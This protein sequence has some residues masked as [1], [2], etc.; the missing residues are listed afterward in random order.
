[1]VMVGASPEQLDRLAS[2]L[3]QAA[4]QIG[5]GIRVGLDR[6]I[7]ANPWQGGDAQR[8][9][10]DWQSHLSP[11]LLRTSESLEQVAEH[12]RLQAEE[13]RV[14]SSANGSGDSTGRGFAS[15]SGGSTGRGFVGGGGGGGGGGGWGDGDDQSVDTG[16]WPF[17][18]LNTLK[19][20]MELPEKIAKGVV[21]PGILTRLGDMEGVFGLSTEYAIL[22]GETDHILSKMKGLS[23]VSGGAD[24]LGFLN[25]AGA[26]LTDPT[27]PDAFVRFAEEA[28][29]LISGAAKFADHA[30]AGRVFGAVG[31][32]LGAYGD[33]KDARD[34]FENGDTFNG[35]YNLVHGGASIVGAFCPVVGA[36]VAAWDIGWSIGT[37]IGESEAF[38]KVI[39]GDFGGAVDSVQK[40]VSSAVDT[41]AKAIGGVAD[42]AGKTINGAANEVGKFLGNPF[43]WGK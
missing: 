28:S 3:G 41:A 29:G 20:V 35:V 7:S 25:S 22:K 21:T 38:T 11:V 5:T 4:S 36:G 6:S 27:D 40:G 33:L 23:V 12:L 26:V 39:S 30:S 15:S 2:S 14:A 9:R 13:Q 34:A 18:S 17:E 1:M 43:G 24:A 37:A 8:F 32:V 31:G 16:K 10:S 42:V 19:K